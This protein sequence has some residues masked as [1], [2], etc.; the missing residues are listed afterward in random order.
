MT[1]NLSMLAGAGAQFFDNNGIPLAGGLIY[2][3]TA[4][5]T[6]PQAAYT[7]SAGSIAHAN[8]IVLDSAGRVPS[9]GEIWLTDAV[10]YKF[11]LKTATSTTIGTYDNVTGNS[12]GIYAAFAAS[13]GA[14][15]VGYIQGGTNSVATT[16]QTKLREILSVKDF[17]ATG[18]GSTNDT[19]AIQAAFS[20][21]SGATIVF[22]KGSYLVTSTISLDGLNFSDIRFEGATILAGVNNL[23]VFKSVTNAWGVKIFDPRIDGNGF[24]GVVAFDVIRLEQLGAGIFRPTLRNLDTGIFLRSLCTGCNIDDPDTVSV[25]NPISVLDSAGGV[26]ISHPRIT[27]YGAIGIDIRIAG[28]YG[29][30]GVQVLGGYVQDGTVGIQDAGTNTQVQGTYFERNTTADVSLI[31][32]SSYF[33]SYGTSHTSNVGAAGYKGRSADAA[34]IENP[35]MS[36][37]A[38][39][40]LFDFDATNTNCSYDVIFG[41]G[42]KN[43][44]IGTTTGISQYTPRQSSGTFTPTIAGATIAGTGTYTSQIGTWERIGDRIFVDITIIWTAHTGSG[45]MQVVGIPSVNPITQALF[46]QAPNPGFAYTGPNIY[47]YPPSIGGANTKYNIAQVSTA[48]TLSF[49]PFVTVGTLVAHIEYLT[50]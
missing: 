33:F 42:G 45:V 6:T 4:G 34:Y 19:T 27:T 8:P 25:D 7:T 20:A 15:L 12:S 46:G 40:G 28:S 30:V 11:V 17:G 38:R 16:V 44:P 14:S 26:R 48:G 23:T 1:V 18:D 37:G 39:T 10:A 13:S 21:A 2:T 41:T 47:L 43:K 24:T 36:S 49:V 3:Y 31:S 9:G 50:T 5:T 22:P 32:G 29:N 35:Y